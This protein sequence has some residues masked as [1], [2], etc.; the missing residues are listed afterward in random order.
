LAG[1][2]HRAAAGVKGH[3]MDLW[4]VPLEGE[5]LLAGGRV[6]H[7]RRPVIARRGQPLAVGAEGHAV[8]PDGVPCEGDVS[9]LDL[10]P[11]EIPLETAQVL[12][13]RAW[14]LVLEQVEHMSHLMLLPGIRREQHV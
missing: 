13:T 9:P 4:G 7:P 2:G 1:R 11:P 8:D 6:P 14:F 3:A 12:L 5:S 10:V